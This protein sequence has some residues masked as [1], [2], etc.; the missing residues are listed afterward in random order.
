MDLC[1]GTKHQYIKM[2]MIES[3]ET[4]WVFLPGKVEICVLSDNIN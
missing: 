3:D 2:S 1:R 4:K